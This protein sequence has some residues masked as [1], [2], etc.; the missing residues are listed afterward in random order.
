MADEGQDV[1]AASSTATGIETGTSAGTL[2]T[3][4]A[5]TGAQTQ[6][7]FV[8]FSRFKEVNDRAGALERSHAAVVQRAAQ[9]E[10]R[11]QQLETVKPA[12][13]PRTPEEQRARA[14][15]LQAL[16][17]LVG[18]DPKWK[19]VL[20]LAQHGPQI[21]QGLQGVQNLTRA[22]QDGLVRGARTELSSLAKEAGLPHTGDALDTIEDI[23]TG[24]I[25]RDP[26]A[27]QKFQQ[28]DTSVV[29]AAFK[30]LADGFVANLR[31]SST[32]TLVD[33]KN[34]VRQLPPVS[35]GGPA[36]PAAPAKLELGKEREY[37]AGLHKTAR[38]R[39]AEL[40][41]G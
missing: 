14:D 24:I 18:D 10:R 12:G 38:A 41:T 28:G 4:T 11:L 22:Q 5:Q 3:D 2:N 37:E 1:G 34:K 36:G 6:S 30:K 19:A 8:P 17:D 33:T 27:M 21:V 7:Q 29:S 20:A 31:R 35:R 15:A 32:A 16:N 9:L 26:D 25:G 23:V 13:T 39:L 40:L